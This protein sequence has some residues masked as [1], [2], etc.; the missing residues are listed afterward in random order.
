MKLAAIAA[1]FV[2]LA[3]GT[4]LAHAA[5]SADGVFS[6]SE[7][8]VDNGD[9]SYTYDYALTNVSSPTVAWLLVVGTNS[10]DISNK[11]GFA[12]WDAGSSAASWT[13]LGTANVVATSDTQDNP[14]FGAL[15][16]ALAQGQSF[17]G[18]SYTSTL[19]DPSPKGFVIDV[20][21]FWSNPEFSYEGV[22]TPATAAVPE[23]SSA[24]LLLAGAGLLAFAARRRRA[25]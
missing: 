25:N 18:F 11:T 9:G 12:G 17:D 19:Y 16:H 1:A 20:A 6:V 14:P 10:T 22:T 8:I 23:N 15:P 4:S 7:M 24:A 2:A 5:A 3:G 13:P 21:G